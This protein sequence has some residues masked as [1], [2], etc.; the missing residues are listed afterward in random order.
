V[1]DNGNTESS[2][3]IRDLPKTT[4]RIDFTALNA[5]DALIT[6]PIPYGYQTTY[7]TTDGGSTWTMLKL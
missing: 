5:N 6:L 1:T 4:D 7:Q 2:I 3:T